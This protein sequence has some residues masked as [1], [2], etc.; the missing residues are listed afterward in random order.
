MSNHEMAGVDCGLYWGG[1]QQFLNEIQTAAN[2]I[3]RCGEKLFLMNHFLD[4]TLD[5]LKKSPANGVEGVVIMKTMIHWAV[6]CI[7]YSI[8][9][10]IDRLLF[11]R[12]GCYVVIHEYIISS[13]Q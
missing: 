12:L 5:H 8:Y 11:R 9:V 2:V 6:I 13:F 3:S 7:G 1:L 4:V 10:Y